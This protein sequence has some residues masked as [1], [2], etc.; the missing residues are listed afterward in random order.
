MNCLIKRFQSK[1]HAETRKNMD[2]LYIDNHFT[3]SYGTKFVYQI[4]YLWHL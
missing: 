4:K 3:K 2:I 1:F